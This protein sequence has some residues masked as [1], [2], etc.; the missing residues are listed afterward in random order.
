MAFIAGNLAAVYVN[1]FD[2]S[3]YL[4][5]ITTKQSA[6]LGET[7]TFGKSF[8]TR[9]GLLEDGMI[10]CAGLFDGAADAVD[11]DLQEILGVVDKMWTVFP[12][13]DTNGAQGRMCQ[14]NESSYETKS[15]V[16]GVVAI[17]AEASADDGLDLAISLHAKG[18]E[19][20]TGNGTAHNNGAATTGG[21]VAILH[22]FAVTAGDTLDVIVQGSTTG[23]WAGEEVTVG[24]FTQV[25]DTGA[26]TAQR[27]TFAGTVQQ[28][29]RARWTIGG[30]APSF[31]F[32]M[33]YARR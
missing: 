29:I 24:T 7:T 21:G 30:V 28:Y 6:N 13:G 12:P 27:I 23:A 8:V 22:V 18:A 17:T 19:T 32:H 26:N 10:S 3:A 16:D 1:G 11:E 5:E 4:Q 15:P 9:I 2:L 25:T 31:N 14:A 20:A 33:A